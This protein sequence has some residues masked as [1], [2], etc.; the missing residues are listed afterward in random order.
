[1]KRKKK[2]YVLWKHR[3]V[4][5]TGR[6]AQNLLI[7]T[8]NVDP[9]VTICTVNFSLYIR[10]KTSFV[11]TLYINRK[12]FALYIFFPPLTFYFICVLNI[13]ST[14]FFVFIHIYRHNKISY[15]ITLCHLL[16]VAVCTDNRVNSDHNNKNWLQTSSRDFS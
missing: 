7:F 11:N 15:F 14:N 13:T 3:N 16:E 4:L 9:A 8:T 1:M 5:R 2:N 12:A 6:Y 10:V